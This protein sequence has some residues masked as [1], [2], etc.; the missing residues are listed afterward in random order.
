MLFFSELFKFIGDS[1]CSSSP[2]PRYFHCWFGFGL[3]QF[4]LLVILV[5]G[6]VEDH[7]IQKVV[8]YCMEGSV[9]FVDLLLN[10]KHLTQIIEAHVII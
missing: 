1:P 10:F 2:W 9:D 8:D 7:V 5:F 3:F 6:D 4:F